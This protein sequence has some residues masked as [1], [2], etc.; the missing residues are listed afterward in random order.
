MSL[1]DWNSNY[2]YTKI[3]STV[4]TISYGNCDITFTM[5][6]NGGVTKDQADC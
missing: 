3:S 6:Y 4:G 5:T 1:D 2:T